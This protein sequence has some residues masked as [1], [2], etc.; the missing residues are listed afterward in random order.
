MNLEQTSRV[1]LTRKSRDLINPNY[2]Q[3]VTQAINYRYHKLQYIRF[4]VNE[5]P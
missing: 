5:W 4:Q 3:P 1:A 2:T